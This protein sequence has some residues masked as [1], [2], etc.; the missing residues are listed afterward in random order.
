VQQHG[1]TSHEV[2][3][4]ENMTRTGTQPRPNVELFCQ[5]GGPNHDKSKKLYPKRLWERLYNQS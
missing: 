5:S 1:P 3:M 4:R 2:G